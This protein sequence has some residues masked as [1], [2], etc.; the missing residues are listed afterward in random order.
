MADRAVPDFAKVALNAALALLPERMN[1]I[2][3]RV[4]VHA[5]GMQESKFATRVQF[6]PKAAGNRGPA[7]GLH[8]FERGGITGLMKHPATKDHLVSL[9]AARQVDFHLDAIYS[10]IETDDILDAG[11]SRLNL[12]WDAAALPR[13]NQP[14][15]GWELYL[16]T[17]RPGHPRKNDWMDSWESACLA[18]DRR[19][20]PAGTTSET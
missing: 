4:I 16:R 2:E 14:W 17:W 11:L 9:C 3:A 5:I 7:R 8:Q 20:N 10:A 15:L 1:T 12:W 13:M 19:A 18:L 6:S